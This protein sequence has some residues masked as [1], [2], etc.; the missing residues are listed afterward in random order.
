MFREKKESRLLIVLKGGKVE[1]QATNIDM[2]ELA[3]MCGA[4]EQLMGVE[5]IRLIFILQL[6]G[7]YLNRLSGKRRRIV[8]AKKKMNKSER[9][10]RSD[11]KKDM[12]KKGLVPPDKPRLNRKKY[13]EEA[14]E[15]WNGKD[16]EYYGWDIWLN[17][18]ISYML[19]RKDQH[20][21]VS[22]EAVGVAKTLKLAIRLKEFHDKL[23]AEERTSYTIGEQYDY[24]RDILDA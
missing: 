19:L 10:I 17:A 21:R 15:E 1:F 4:L 18:A 5:A 11:V 20:L 22:S 24:I 12:Q 3:T 7:L 9:K 6:C 8:T 2:V 23:K 16:G 13:I 14:K